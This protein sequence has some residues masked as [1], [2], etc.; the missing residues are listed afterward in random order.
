[1]KYPHLYLSSFP[2]LGSDYERLADAMVKF[3]VVSWL[4]YGAQLFGYTLI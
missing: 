3:Y 1:M 2:W 4:G